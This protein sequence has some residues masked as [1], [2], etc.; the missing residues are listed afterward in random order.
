MPEDKTICPYCGAKMSKWEVPRLSTWSAE[1][2]YVCFNDKC[3]YY[4]KGWEHMNETTHVGCSYRHRYDPDTGHCGP[5][6]VWSPEAGKE[7]IIA[8]ES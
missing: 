5:L 7:R 2:F 3:S 8:E 6:P 4:V 1:Y